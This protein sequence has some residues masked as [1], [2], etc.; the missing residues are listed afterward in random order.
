MVRNLKHC[1]PLY[2]SRAS[3]ARPPVSGRCAFVAQYFVFERLISDF[4]VPIIGRLPFY[5]ERKPLRSREQTFALVIKKVCAHDEKLP[6]CVFVRPVIS[7][8]NKISKAAAVRGATSRR[9]LRGEKRRKGRK[10]VEN[11]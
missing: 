9:H 3:F 2:P 11:H 1:R 5:H 6:C 8:G 7:H 10:R 4:R